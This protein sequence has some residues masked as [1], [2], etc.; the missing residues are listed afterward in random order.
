MKMKR[1][2]AFVLGSFG[3]FA[4]VYAC[5]A[6]YEVARDFGNP[7]VSF[8]DNLL[9][10]TLF[11][12]LGLAAGVAGLRLW[13]FT[14][15]GT[16]R[17]PNAFSSIVLG[18]SCFFPGFVFSALLLAAL[19]VLSGHRS[20]D[21]VVWGL[22]VALMLGVASMIAGVLYFLR[23]QKAGARNS[24]SATNPTSGAQEISDLPH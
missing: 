17:A 24:S 7:S 10:T 23:K 18:L 12:C 20:N 14:A 8:W 5:G 6:T 3:L 15:T 2:F 19:A 16:I 4:C 21:E 11:A 9:G 22:C 13:R 1:E